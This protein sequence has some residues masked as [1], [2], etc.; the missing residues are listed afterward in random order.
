MLAGGVTTSSAHIF[1][2][3]GVGWNGRVEGLLRPFSAT[4]IEFVAHWMMADG[5]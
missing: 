4:G 3:H 2:R 1:L 5:E